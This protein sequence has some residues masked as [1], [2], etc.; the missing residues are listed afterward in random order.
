MDKTWYYLTHNDY[1]EIIKPLPS[2]SKLKWQ[3]YSQWR[4][5]IPMLLKSYNKLKRKYGKLSCSQEEKE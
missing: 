3:L 1:T 5:H 4:Q 2:N